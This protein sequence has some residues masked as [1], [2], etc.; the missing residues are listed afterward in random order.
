MNKRFIKETINGVTL[1]EIQAAAYRNIKRA[2][3]TGGAVYVSDA[4]MDSIAWGA[5]MEV[6]ERRDDYVEVVFVRWV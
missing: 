2:Y 5:T 1:E 3:W 6:Y 4:D